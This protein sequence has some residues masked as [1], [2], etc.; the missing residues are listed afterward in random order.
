[1]HRLVRRASHGRAALGRAALAALVLAACDGA[2]APASDT[3]AVSPDSAAPAPLAGDPPGC[4]AAASLGGDGVGPLRIGMRLRDLPAGCTTRDTAVVLSEGQRESAHVVEIAG[5]PVVAV[6]TG[7]TD[8]TVARVIVADSGLR[9]TSGSGVGST[10][11]ELRRRHPR[12]CGALGEGTVVVRADEQPGIAFRV[13]ADFAAM[14][15]AERALAQDASP[16]P[17]STRVVELWLVGGA[18]RCAP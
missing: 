7:S 3:A 12:L 18:L 14:A 2:G 16:V 10:M 9:T 5:R 15:A 13:A 11:A 1:M 6:T 4:A 17:D 8:S